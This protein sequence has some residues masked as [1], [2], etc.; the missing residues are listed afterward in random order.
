MAGT[1]I[2]ALA[3]TG[4]FCEESEMIKSIFTT[5]GKRENRITASILAVLSSLSID[6]AQQIISALLEESEFEMITFQNQPSKGSKGVPDA[7]ISASFKILIETKTKIKRN[8][9]DTKDTKQIRQHLE[10]LDK[11]NES[12]KKLLV[13]TPDADLPATIDAIQD[14][15]LCWASFA[16]LDQAIDEL[17][18]N[19]KEVIS[20]REAFLLRELQAMLSAEELITFDK[21]VLVIP[22]K[23]A[24]P[25]YNESYAYVC[26]ADRSFQP[27]SHLAFYH[28]N[29]IYGLIPKIIEVHNRVEMESGRF[30]GKLGQLVDELLD[31][32][33]RTDGRA[34]KVMLLS[35]P[36]APETI[37]LEKPIRNNLISATGR[38]IAFTMNQRYVDIKRLK[39]ATTTSELI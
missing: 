20:E 38:R 3:T 28:A 35:Q 17:L 13:L 21:K 30:K 37:R 33:L 14:K 6:R 4:H 9:I 2:Y 15:R 34:Y 5:Y 22:A 1:I 36:D 16:A 11:S 25:E 19:V 12:L 26:Q 32:K 29:Q 31:K 18:G 8:S 23:N 27:V 39:N 10:R 24:W 7:E